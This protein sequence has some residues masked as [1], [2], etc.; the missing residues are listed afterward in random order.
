MLYAFWCLDVV[1]IQLYIFNVKN[2]SGPRHGSCFPARKCEFPPSSYHNWP[3]FHRQ[4]LNEK[5]KK[6]LTFLHPWMSWQPLSAHHQKKNFSG[7]FSFD[8]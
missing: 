5:Q 1:W 3:Q 7:D 8:L 4:F 2:P 6:E